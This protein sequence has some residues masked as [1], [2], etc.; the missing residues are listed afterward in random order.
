MSYPARL[1]GQ[2]ERGATPVMQ[3]RAF[4]DGELY[5]R[6]DGPGVRLPDGTQ[7]TYVAFRDLFLPHCLPKPYKRPIRGLWWR[8]K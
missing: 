2:Y 6:S 7:L 4:P 1:L 5:E 8:W 3:P